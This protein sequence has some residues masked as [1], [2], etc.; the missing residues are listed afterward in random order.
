MAT[1]SGNA[2]IA[3]AEPSAETQVPAAFHTLRKMLEEEPFRFHFFQAVRLLQKMD[4]ER[5]PVGY[6]ITPQG[7]TIRFSSRPTLGFPPSELCALKQTEN[8]QMAMTVEFMGMCAAIAVMPSV[9]TEYLLERNREKDHAFEE[10]LNIFNHRMISFF[11][12]GW[13]KYRIFVEYEKSGTDKLSARLFDLLGLGTEGL[14]GRSGVPDKAF[15][16]YVGVLARCARSAASLQQILEEYFEV[17]IRI[18]QFAGTWR[19]LPPDNHTVFWGL[20]GANERLGVGVVAGDEVWDQHGRI[21]I[22]IGPMRLR[23]YLEFLP[24]QTAH[25][26]LVAWLRFYSNGNYEAEI[27]LV[28]AA[29]DVPAC[30]L[31]S[32]GEARPQLGLVSWLKTRP[33]AHDPADATYLV[34]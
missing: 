1:E 20:G 14:Q 3:L 24:G 2:G 5:G 10:F 28:L 22:F 12:R 21:R 15:L 32:R 18:Q 4:R 7:E 29:E 30:A 6:F 9:Y 31:G 16:H 34:P 26:D 11:Y 8:G 33:L 13:E 27:K 25:H 17:P 19:K 23:Q